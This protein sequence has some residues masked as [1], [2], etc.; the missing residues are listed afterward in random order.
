MM[1]VD[2]AADLGLCFSLCYQF[3][4]LLYVCTRG[5]EKGVLNLGISEQNMKNLGSR[6]LENLGFSEE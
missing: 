6:K 2:Y 5:G 3:L 1:I 4:F